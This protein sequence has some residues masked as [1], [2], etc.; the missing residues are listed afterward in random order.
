MK[1]VSLTDYIRWFSDNHVLESLDGDWNGVVVAVIGD[2]F[3][4][5]KGD[6]SDGK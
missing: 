3:L 5:R 1:E 4:I 6:V 2:S